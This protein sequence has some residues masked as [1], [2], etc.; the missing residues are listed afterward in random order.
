MVRVSLVWSSL[1]WI[2]SG[3]GSAR[4]HSSFHFDFVIPDTIFNLMCLFPTNRGRGTTR[5]CFSAYLS[6]CLAHED[7]VELIFRHSCLLTK[8]DYG[9]NWK[10][11]LH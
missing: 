11:C 4:Q 8:Y 2:S 10:F 9:K 6:L 7:E 1:F 5:S 3:S